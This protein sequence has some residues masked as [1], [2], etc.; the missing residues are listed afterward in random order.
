MKSEGLLEEIKLRVDIVEL[1][2]DYVSLKKAGQNYK[3]LCPFHA[4]K[5]PSFVVSPSKQIF[6]CFGCGAGG[7]IVTFLMKHE[8]LSFAEVIRYLAKK[9]GIDLRGIK[10]DKSNIY[11]MREKLIHINEEALKIFRK[12][13]DNSEIAKKYLE[14]RGLNRESILNFHIGYANDEGN[15]LLKN[16]K[17]LGFNESLLKEA[18][19]V[20]A[21]GNGYRDLFR[22]RIIFPIYNLQSDLIAFGGRVIDDSLPKYINS[23]E[24]KIFRKGE[25]L[26]AI[27]IAKENIK[28]KGYAIIVEGYLDTIICH[29][30]GFKNTIAPL[31]TA[32][33][34]MHLQKLKLLTKN[35]VL[36]FD[37]D[38]AGVSAAR[39]ALTTISES[40]FKAK[41]LLLPETE[42]PDSFLRKNGSKAFEKLLANA[43]SMVEF[44][45]KTSK[46][47]KSDKVRETL[48]IIALIKDLIIAEEMLNELSDRMRIN[49]S[50]LREELEKIRKK[51][52]RSKTNIDTKI[53]RESFNKEERLLLSVILSFPEKAN[54]VFSRLN[55]EDVSDITIRLILEKIKSLKDNFNIKTLLDDAEEK[56]KKLI[57][58]L[59]L[60]PGFD[61]EHVNENIEDCLYFLRKKRFEEMRKI[62]EKNSDIVI[63]DSLL[64]EKRNLIK[65]SKYESKF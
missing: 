62:A 20:T 63:L 30:Y 29:Q 26:F 41:V 58:E 61:P 3:G 60:E 18:G 57:T 49:E 7:D 32:L 51:L 53:I 11:E 25:S 31:G 14:R 9:V 55:I 33:T 24:T 65:R 37:A 44:L 59:L 38:E 16:M 34:T 12:N 45:L 46:E 2:S 43:M 40:D 47:D 27:N 64:K 19:I 35:V 8:N 1:I 15:S 52:K 4:E 36:I 17:R 6:H 10:L 54:Y 13:L 21:F 50:I 23:P 48:N 5:T 39:K 28:N 42:D 22:K 56:E